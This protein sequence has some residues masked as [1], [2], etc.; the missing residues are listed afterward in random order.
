MGNRVYSTNSACVDAR[1]NATT[2]SHPIQCDFLGRQG[3][4][5]DA[6]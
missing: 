2:L 4:D 6:N 3:N 1:R 5:R